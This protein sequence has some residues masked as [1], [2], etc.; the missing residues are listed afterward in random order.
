[1]TSGRSLRALDLSLLDSCAQAVAGRSSGLD[2]ASVRRAID[3]VHF[4]A[5]RRVRGGP[6]PAE[7]T[8][9][10]REASVR[11]EADEARVAQLRRRLEEARAQREQWI[12][13]ALQ[14]VMPGT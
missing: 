3:P 7:M 4:V 9:Y 2:E 5:V 13:Q 12:E 14:G 11:R 1:T 10:L 8:R 6:A